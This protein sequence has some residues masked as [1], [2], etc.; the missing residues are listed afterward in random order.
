LLR[1]LKKILGGYFF[2]PHPVYRRWSVNCNG[3]RSNNLG[4][5][6]K[7]ASWR[8]TCWLRTGAVQRITVYKTAQ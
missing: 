7:R 5:L 2:L 1:K 6:A 3:N 4:R 8:A